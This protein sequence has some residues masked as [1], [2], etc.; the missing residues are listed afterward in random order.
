MVVCKTCSDCNHTC[1]GYGE[2][3]IHVRSKSDTASQRPTIASLSDGHVGS[4]RASRA[5]ESN[6]PESTK[7]T[8]AKSPEVSKLWSSKDASPRVLK[9]RQRSFEEESPA[10]S[11]LADEIDSSRGCWAC[12]Y[13]GRLT[14]RT[15]QSFGNRTHVPYFRYFGP[16]AI[17]P[18]Y[19]QMVRTFVILP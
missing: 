2:P 4:P 19:K 17:V 14:G 7:V 8:I 10:S 3:S 9:E 6:S 1:L 12:A 15:S 13:L 11:K 16:T 5:V 18:G